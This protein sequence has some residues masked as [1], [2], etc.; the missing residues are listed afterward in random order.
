MKKILS[1]L[2]LATVLL[3]LNAQT[4]VPCE[5]TTPLTNGTPVVFGSA[6]QKTGNIAGT[7]FH[8]EIWLDSRNAGSREVSFEYYGK[9]Q[10][11]GAAFK[12]SWVEPNNYLARTGYFWNNGGHY[13]Q[14]KN[15][16]CDFN[17]TRSGRATTGTWSY[18]GIYGWSRNPSR[19]NPGEKMTEY[20]IVEDWFGNKW[21]SD[22]TPVNISTT[23]GSVVG[24]I[25]VD[26]SIYDIVMNVKTNAPSPNNSNDTFVQI[27]SIRR[28]QRKCG[29]ISVTEHFKK[30]EELGLV[31]GERMYE[32]KFKVEAGKGTGWI[33]FSYL[34]FSQEDPNS[35][36]TLT[37]NVSPKLYVNTVNSN[38]NVNFMAI[39]SGETHL[40]LYSVTGSL[41]SSAQLKT[42]AGENY[43]YTFSREKLSSG[44]YIVTMQNNGNVEQA[45]VVI[46]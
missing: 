13:T 24:T 38:V 46:P 40:G 30:W 9:D 45:K 36:N 34:T 29:R 3:P 28:K 26:G 12:S 2:C 10:G 18:I 37:V 11:G 42:V 25:N 33:D 20:Y 19:T 22:T 41:V 7:P 31:F 17:F 5:Q 35:N 16:F 8:Y 32:C 1:I 43:S 23:G 6:S 15:I 44:I 27:F 21:Q 39:E 14:Y 4:V